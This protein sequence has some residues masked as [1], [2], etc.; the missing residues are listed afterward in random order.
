MLLSAL[1]LDE[2]DLWTYE[3]GIWTWISGNYSDP[4]GILTVYKDMGYWSDGAIGQRVPG[5]YW[6]YEDVLWI[7]GGLGA[8]AGF[9]IFYSL[10]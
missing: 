6:F 10:L 7:F 5:S 2:N 4:D 3:S 1:I 8:V 9:G